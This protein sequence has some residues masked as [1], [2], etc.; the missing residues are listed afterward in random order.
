MKKILIGDVSLRE[1]GKKG[2]LNLSFK[3]KLE[4]AKKLNELNVDYIELGEIKGDKAEEV[5]VKTLS[6]IINKSTL[7]VVCGSTT[8]SIEKTFALISAAKRKRLC[9]ALPV[10]AVQME[11]YF[12][13]KPKAVNELVKTLTEKATSLCDDVEVI[14]SDATRAESSFLYENVKTA[15]VCGAK[16]VTLTDLTGDM[17]PEEFAE[18]IANIY[19][20]VPE[21]KDVT[22]GLE[23]SDAFSMATVNYITAFGK[24]A[25][26]VK[27]SAIGGEDTADIP[28]FQQAMDYIAGK[29]GYSIG[30]NKTALK[31]IVAS[32]KEIAGRVVKPTSTDLSVAENSEIKKEVTAAGLNKI[33]K[34]R[35]YDLSASDSAKVYAEF[36]RISEKKA[37][38]VKELDA[39]IASTALQV[40][41]TYTLSK[42]SIQS[43]NVITATAN[44]VALKQGEELSGLS[45]GNGPIDAAFLALENI[46]G[47]H[48]ELDDFTIASVT[49]GKE[50]MGET[51]VKL[52]H[53]GKIYSGRGLSTDIV[54]ASIRA[55][56]NAVNKIVYEES[57]K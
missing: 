27:L 18:F 51:V 4:I 57:N 28:V 25:G 1:Y 41:E 16:T 17:M 15:I 52:R 33:I 8:E 44:I 11:Y 21:L 36:K 6:T 48:F 22:L 20:N 3:E 19:N 54:G 35:G 12:G 53:D 30:L 45:F 42:Y 46:I 47:R 38:G 49:E 10:S 40:P 32:I 23:C 50:A 39:I 43:S 9:V 31:G 56:I 29:K 26:L 24:G 13:K 55:Y 34:K 14:L 7:S 5:L 37:V 2:N